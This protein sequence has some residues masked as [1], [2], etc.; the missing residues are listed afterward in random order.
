MGH[1]H[2][3][4]IRT[5]I[6]LSINFQSSITRTKFHRNPSCDLEDE[7]CGRRDKRKNRSIMPQTSATNVAKMDMDDSRWPKARYL[8]DR[9]RSSNCSSYYYW[10]TDRH[11]TM[12]PLFTNAESRRFPSSDV[13]PRATTPI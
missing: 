7:T 10:W 4:S 8:V 2:I 12:S 1:R 13:Y 9:G 11:L 6:K 3:E 5:E